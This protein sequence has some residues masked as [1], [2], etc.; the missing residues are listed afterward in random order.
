MSSDPLVKVIFSNHDVISESLSNLAN[1]TARRSRINWPLPHAFH[2]PS[3]APGSEE[4]SSWSMLVKLKARED[5]ES[6]ARLLLRVSVTSEDARLAV[7]INACLQPD[8]F[9]H[10]LHFVPV[11]S[12]FFL[13]SPVACP[14]AF[15]QPSRSGNFLPFVLKHQS[16]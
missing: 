14:Q 1:F 4:K 11:V 7:K 15:T 8:T 2:A 3:T 9:I 10:L 13:L 12:S 5:A 16:R 6:T